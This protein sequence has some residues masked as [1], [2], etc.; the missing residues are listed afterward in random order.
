MGSLAQSFD[1][2]FYLDNRRLRG[3]I[4]LN[5]RRPRSAKSTVVTIDLIGVSPHPILILLNNFQF[6]SPGAT[7]L[8][9]RHTFPFCRRW[10]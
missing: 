9:G 6:K 1:K 7:T 4:R 2:V 8:F 5:G 3:E 10:K